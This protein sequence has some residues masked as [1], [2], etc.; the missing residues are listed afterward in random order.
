MEPESDHLHKCLF[1]E[2]SSRSVLGSQK[3]FVPIGPPA[4]RAGPSVPSPI[5]HDRVVTQRRRGEAE[6]GELVPRGV[7][8]C[9]NGEA[10]RAG[11][12]AKGWKKAMQGRE[13]RWQLQKYNTK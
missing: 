6:L 3:H 7:G 11:A 2:M 10:F 8:V 5:C 12:E 13:A 1:G 4:I 9:V